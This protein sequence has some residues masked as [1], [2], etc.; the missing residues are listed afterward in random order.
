M[1]G[2]AVSRFA[3]APERFNDL[4]GFIKRA[5]EPPFANLSRAFGNMLFNQNSLTRKIIINRNQFGNR[6]TSP[7][8]DNLFTGLD[9]QKQPRQLGLHLIDVYLNHDSRC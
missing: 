9:S 6:H 1:N 5:E 2:S 7:V 8:D 3:F 4:I